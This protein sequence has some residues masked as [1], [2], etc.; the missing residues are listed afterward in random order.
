MLRPSLSPFR[1]MDTVRGAFLDLFILMDSPAPLLRMCMVRRCHAGQE[2]V[3]VLRQLIPA[4]KAA[5][6]KKTK[7]TRMQQALALDPM[8][9]Q[10]DHHPLVH[11]NAPSV[12]V[13]LYTAACFV[14]LCS[15]LS[16]LPVREVSG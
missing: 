8:D 7:R 15:L 16:G 11:I 12:P 4:R 1:V 5:G 3:D 14:V 6:G 13:G 2:H 10:A 9:L